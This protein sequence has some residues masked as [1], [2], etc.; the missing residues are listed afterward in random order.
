MTSSERERKRIGRWRRNGKVQVRCV[1]CGTVGS[2][3][4]RTKVAARKIQREY[5]HGARL[6][7]GVCNDSE[8]CLIRAMTRNNPRRRARLLLADRVGLTLTMRPGAE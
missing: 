4:V 1:R 8:R 2:N 7:L 3:G 5:H 6:S